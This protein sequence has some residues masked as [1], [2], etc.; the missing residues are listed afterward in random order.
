MFGNFR[1]LLRTVN[2]DDE[3]AALEEIAHRVV[4]EGMGAAAIMFLESSRPVSFIAGQAAIAATPLIGGFIEPMRL[5]KYATLFGNRAFVDRLI[6]RIEE[7]ENE[8]DDA[9]REEKRRKKAEK[10][11]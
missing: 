10:K 6:A 3:E 9:R 2:L 4:N 1:D 8:R 7:L 5:E 11:Q